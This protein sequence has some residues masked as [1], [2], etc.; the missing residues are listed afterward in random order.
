MLQTVSG[1]GLLDLNNTSANSTYKIPGPLFTQRTYPEIPDYSIPV[2][3][4]T[5]SISDAQ[6]NANTVEEYTRLE[7]GKTYYLEVS[8]VSVSGFGCCD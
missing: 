4:K 5:I 3:P 8:A 1:Q 7:P 2:L 6:I